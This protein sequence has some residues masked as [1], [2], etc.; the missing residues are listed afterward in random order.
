M[1]IAF[2]FG[3]VAQSAHDGA[4]PA[5]Y[6]AMAPEA[7]SGAYYGPTRLNETRGAPGESRIFPQAA[8]TAAASRLWDLSE[9]LTGVSFSL[10]L[11]VH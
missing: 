9:K 8:D 7:K 10:P 2:A 6:A 11:P 4:L 3:M 5:L 1:L